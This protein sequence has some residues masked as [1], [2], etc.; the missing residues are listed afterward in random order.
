MWRTGADVVLVP[1]VMVVAGPSLVVVDDVME[2]SVVVV[3]SEG[4]VVVELGGS[5]ED[6]LPVLVVVCSSV[7]VRPAVVEAGVEVEDESEVVDP[8]VV[9]GG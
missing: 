9:L 5:V 3:D 2:L 4:E 7:V 1:E 8:A 6:A